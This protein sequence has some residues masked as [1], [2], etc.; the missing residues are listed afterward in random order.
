MKICV[1]KAN[2]TSIVKQAD[3]WMI[4]GNATNKPSQKLKP[5]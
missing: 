1:V 3:F 2:I 5:Y 4:I